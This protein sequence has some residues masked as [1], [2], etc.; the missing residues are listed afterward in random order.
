MQNYHEILGVIAV[1]IG[2]VSYVPYFRDIFLNKTKPH[3]FSW[4][5]WGI[6]TSIAFVAQV[7]EQ[8]GPGAWVTGITAVACFLISVVSFVKG[9]R[10]FPKL[11]WMFLASAIL[12]LL[13]WWQTKDP[14]L[15]VILITVTDALSFCPTFRKGYR[16]PQEE[17][18]STF[19]ASATKFLIG[20]VALQSFAVVN[21]IYQASLVLMNGA[22]AVMLLVRRQQLRQ[23]SFKR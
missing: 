21:W 1:V 18:V 4:G 3:A 5:M 22:F 6:L 16:N 15:S 10:D 14:L 17:T 2:V 8:A 23:R 13:L 7:T 19:M 12:A 20:I 11:D 9:K